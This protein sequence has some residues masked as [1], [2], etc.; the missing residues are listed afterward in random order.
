M[1]KKD[2]FEKAKGGVSPDEIMRML[3]SADRAA[4]EKLLNDKAATQKLLQS[5]EAKALYL[6]LFGGD[7][8]G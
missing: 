2:I 1:D 6:A 8:N 4:V 3:S 5:E 7:I